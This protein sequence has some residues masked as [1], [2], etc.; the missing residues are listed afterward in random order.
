MPAYRAASGLA[1][2]VRISKPMVERYRIHHTMG[3][4]A[5]AMS[6]PACSSCPVPPARTGMPASPTDVVRANVAPR[7]RSGSLTAHETI[8]RAM[9][10]SMMVTT[11]SWAPV[12]ALSQPGMKP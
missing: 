9:K 6:T 3:T 12:K 8:W 5:S 1:P 10:L 4:A 2:T 11:T 7:A